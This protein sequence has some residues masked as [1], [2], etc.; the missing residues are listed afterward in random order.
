MTA[1]AFV[2][3]PLARFWIDES[4]QDLVEYALISALVGLASI[5][6]IHGIAA[7]IARSI[8]VV[9]NGFNNVVSAAV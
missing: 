2:L 5:T 4:G 8:T 6:G 7:T 3:P 1:P 9:V